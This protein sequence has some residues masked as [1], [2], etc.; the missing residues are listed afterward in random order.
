MFYSLFPGMDESWYVTPPACF[1]QPGPVHVET[2]PLEDLLIEHPSMS[3]YRS[4][5]QD[6]PTDSSTVGNPSAAVVFLGKHPRKAAKNKAAGK[7]P[8][9][10]L[11]RRNVDNVGNVV[12][13]VGIVGHPNG[14]VVKAPT[15]ANDA[16]SRDNKRGNNN[17][18]N[19]NNNHATQGGQE[20]VVEEMPRRTSI[21]E[22]RSSRNDENMRI[23]IR[24]SQKVRRRRR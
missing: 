10:P 1:T 11:A 8:R 2:S 18:H 23:Q 19:N 13:N 21:K 7:A 17:N 9:T 3:V 20:G 15:V 22:L 6:S 24:S 16:R 4:A 5:G 14:L 12:S